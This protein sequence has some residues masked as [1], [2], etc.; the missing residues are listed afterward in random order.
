MQLEQFKEW[1]SKA[2]AKEGGQIKFAD[3]HGIDRAV[4][5]L[6]MSGKREPSKEFAAAL[7]WRKNVTYSKEAK[8]L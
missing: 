4:M 1:I 5:S 6:V 8:K 3:K 2:I 7:G